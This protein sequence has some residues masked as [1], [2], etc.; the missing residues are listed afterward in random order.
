MRGVT[1]TLEK[2]CFRVPA[3][4]GPVK[5]FTVTVPAS[6]LVVVVAVL[7]PAVPVRPG[8]VCG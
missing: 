8:W 7:V 6:A 2:V 1:A 5:I 4:F 3:V